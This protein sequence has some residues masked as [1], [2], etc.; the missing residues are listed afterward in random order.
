M[1]RPGQPRHPAALR[2]DLRQQRRQRA[3]LRR[4]MLH[5]LRLPPLGRWERDGRLR[6]RVPRLLPRALRGPRVRRRLGELLAAV[7]RSG[8]ADRGGRAG[9]GNGA[10]QSHG[11][12]H[13]F[14]TTNSW[15]YK[16]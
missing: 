15:V 2:V 9:A 14:C 12:C 4:P 10:V 8:A 16:T 3:A 6:A 11:F 7:R 5:R 1:R 13:G